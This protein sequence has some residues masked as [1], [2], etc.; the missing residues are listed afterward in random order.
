MHHIL[1]PLFDFYYNFNVK[2]TRQ[3][4]S[5]ALDWAK[6]LL[7]PILEQ[8]L[9]EFDVQGVV[10][11]IEELKI[12]LGDVTVQNIESI[13]PERFRKALREAIQQKI[14]QHKFNLKVKSIDNIAEIDSIFEL[15]VH[16]LGTGRGSWRL[17]KLSEALENTLHSQGI[18]WNTSQDKIM[19][20]SFGEP[21]GTQA[22]AF[23][24]EVFW[25]II[26]QAEPHVLLSWIAE[27]GHD[28][29]IQKRMAR[30]IKPE[31]IWAWLAGKNN[32]ILP[33]LQNMYNIFYKLNS[34]TWEMPETQLKGIFTEA[35]LQIFDAKQ[36]FNAFFSKT[37]N[38]E[39]LLN[40]ILKKQ[41]EAN[42][43][44]IFFDAYYPHIYKF[45]AY[46]T[47]INTTHTYTFLKETLIKT[48]NKRIEKS[49]AKQEI[50]TKKELSIFIKNILGDANEENIIFQDYAEKI[51][52]YLSENDIIFSTKLKNIWIAFL[53]SR[54]L[55]TF[56]YQELVK[57]TFPII[58]KAY[59]GYLEQK[60]SQVEEY[61]KSN[62]QK[63]KKHWGENKIEIEINLLEKKIN[64]KIIKEISK[65]NNTAKSKALEVWEK[66]QEKQKNYALP[67]KKLIELLK[68]I[69]PVHAEVILTFVRELA[70]KYKWAKV[71]ALVFKQKIWELVAHYL[72]Y[73]QFTIFN[74]TQF[75]R[76]ILAQVAEHYAW[77]E[78]DVQAIA[79]QIH[80][81][82][83]KKIATENIE[84][85]VEVWRK[86]WRT[87]STWENVA[88]AIF[89]NA[90]NT[91]A[92]YIIAQDVIMY[93]AFYKSSEKIIHLAEQIQSVFQ[94]NKQN[95]SVQSILT[96]WLAY[97]WLQKN[98]VFVFDKEKIKLL[99]IIFNNQ[100]VFFKNITH[101]D[102][103]LI[104]NDIITVIHQKFS[105][106]E[107]E[108]A[109]LNQK[110]TESVSINIK[111]INIFIRY[112]AKK[113]N[114]EIFN[115]LQYFIPDKIYW[116]ENI[117]HLIAKN[118]PDELT[119][120]VDKIK[121][122]L[123][124]NIAIFILAEQQKNISTTAILQT[125]YKEIIQKEYA[126][127]IEQIAALDIFGV[128]Q[129]DILKQQQY[130]LQVLIHFAKT[131][132]WLWSESIRFLKGETQTNR[133]EYL[134]T[135]ILSVPEVYNQFLLRLHNLSDNL[136]ASFIYEIIEKIKNKK[137]LN[138]F[139]KLVNS[140]ALQKENDS[141][142]IISFTEALFIY[143]RNKYIEIFLEKISKNI[144][145]KYEE[146]DTFE[147]LLTYINN[148]TFK[149]Y[150]V[151]AKL[152]YSIKK[153]E[154][155]AINEEKFIE[156]TKESLEMSFNLFEKNKIKLFNEIKNKIEVIK[157]IDNE[158][159]LKV[160]S[161]F[162]LLEN[163]Q[164]A[165]FEILK[166]K[167]FSITNDLLKSLKEIDNELI[168]LTKEQNLELQNFEK[169]LNLSNK[170]VEE[171][172]NL[173]L[174]KESIIW[175]KFYKSPK[176]PSN[177]LTYTWEK[178]AK[179]L[180]PLLENPHKTLDLLRTFFPKPAIHIAL[181][182]AWFKVLQIGNLVEVLVQYFPDIFLIWI[183]ALPAHKQK[184]VEKQNP[185]SIIFWNTNKK[186]IQKE[187]TDIQEAIEKE[188][189]LL[190]EI[191][192]K[193]TKNREE[194]KD[195]AKKIDKATKAW[196]DEPLYIQNAGLVI[197]HPFLSRL[198][199][200][201]EWV[202]GGKFKSDWEASKAVY[203]LEY[204][205][206][207]VY[208]N[209][210]EANLVLN[211]ILC[212]IPI[213]QPLWKD[214]EL[215]EKEKEM[216][217]SLLQGVIQNWSILGKTS[218]EA[219]RYSFLQREGRLTPENSHWRLRVDQKGTDILVERLPWGIGMIKTVYMSY[220]LYVEWV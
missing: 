122:K 49:L 53:E 95:I 206:R 79:L 41:H 92:Q 167:F 22:R 147:K 54:K 8:V 106:T 185:E 102:K 169:S 38:I 161:I 58:S 163:T 23:D 73:H 46:H 119:L 193:P 184:E 149:K 198:F 65:E 88:S 72:L 50:I 188:I 105:F 40:I 120:S 131:G 47:E 152:K 180:L 116:L 181:P 137:L 218:P 177:F 96:Q 34:Y 174:I 130:Q 189:Y 201:L 140:I 215:T 10:M 31:K 153:N 80:L 86:V 30:Q 204:L 207:K 127:T 17:G 42:N 70:S 74:F 160:N 24:F 98:K 108:I 150:I 107:N 132:E 135:T 112:I 78:T 211:K 15:L 111:K 141:K 51:L 134:L 126:Y 217:E 155:I 83:T 109:Y 35:I 94:K 75:I 171:T 172:K 157:N 138:A 154:D 182:A 39:K 199:T 4:Q 113:T 100:I 32:L 85:T 28:S 18:V 118:K 57:N 133:I 55:T 69:E 159:F 13:L 195:L 209:I 37:I 142:K 14:I 3:T 176:P 87:E 67:E 77:Q 114:T 59:I 170:E 6:R 19:R 71:N 104:I 194:L 200:V 56:T 97:R 158:T 186:V 89:E 129:Q 136:S 213:E 145:L 82:E 151:D 48:K 93:L 91:A 16:Y 101:F 61:K 7:L 146:N 156:L 144:I 165:S 36:N 62:L 164:L 121:S 33:A 162:I 175:D 124:K 110:Y 183:N 43:I 117:I 203:M 197:L 143:Q 52:S 191:P 125:L 115:Y 148:E 68:D 5:Q 219:L 90:Q 166:N 1:K 45:L 60:I 173:L 81:P 178:Q 128:T 220:F 66:I 212:G 208:E 123:W 214:V 9:D 64:Q 103:K 2:N 216:G 139:I 187:L 84:K 25:E 20:G 44:S 27:F 21:V 190:P 202:E 99:E 12:D 29:H 168:I 26:K 179:I 205:A 11:R 192:E 210:D 63:I 76:T 196:S